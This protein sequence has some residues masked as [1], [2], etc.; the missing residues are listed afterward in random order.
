MPKKS[1]RPRRNPQSPSP[2]PPAFSPLAMDQTMANVEKLLAS[3][4]FQSIDEANAFLQKMLREHGGQLPEVAPSTPL[5]QA[6][7]L[8]AQ[9]YE[10][11]APGRRRALAQQAL[12]L[13]PDCAD[14][15]ALLAELEPVLYRKLEVME[16]AVA[17][18]RRALG[19]IRFKELEGAFWGFVETRPFMRAYA[20][21]AEFSWALGDRARAIAIYTDMLHLNPGDNQGVRYILA[22][23]LLEE[24]S[25]EAQA[26]LQNLLKRFPDDVAANWAYSRALLFFQLQSHPTDRANQA[27]RKA[28]KANP[29]VPPLLL[30]EEPMP[31]DLPRFIG[32]G[33][34]NEAAEYVAFAHDA[35]RHTSGALPWLRQQ[36]RT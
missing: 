9:A 29:H 32:F 24:R 35:W 26:A 5:E 2:Q 6:Q 15:Y 14:A 13:S 7:A 36:K 27:L 25:P 30:G 12:A 1:S 16:Q 20:A 28:M 17:A 33:D 18:G 31:R 34:V 10:V 22:T 11:T 8:V 19:E 3:Q 4:N 23:C 21:V